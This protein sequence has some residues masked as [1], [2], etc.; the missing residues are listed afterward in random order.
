MPEAGLRPSG[1]GGC[2]RSPS[3]R[4]AQ[5]VSSRNS[6][7]SGITSSSAGP[8]PSGPAASPWAAG[9]LGGLAPSLLVRQGKNIDAIVAADGRLESRAVSSVT[10]G[11][12]STSSSAASAIQPIDG[13]W[14]ISI[15]HK[16]HGANLQPSPGI[17]ICRPLMPRPS[18]K[19]PLTLS[20]SRRSSS[21]RASSGS[22]DAGSRPLKGYANRNLAAANDGLFAN[23]LRRRACRGCRSGRPVEHSWPTSPMEMG[24][25]LVAMH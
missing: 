7:D 18:T 17:T 5:S 8:H 2:A 24:S 6:E 21:Q 25:Q 9:K 3:A 19:V 15:G 23:K 14:V 20:R 4:P 12:T 1:R 13:L 10:A 11:R 22:N 16:R